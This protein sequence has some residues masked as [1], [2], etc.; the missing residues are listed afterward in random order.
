[1]HTHRVAGF[2]DTLKAARC[3]PTGGAIQADA[4]DAVI[5][6][7]LTQCPVVVTSAHTP[8]NNSNTHIRFL[9]TR[10]ILYTLIQHTP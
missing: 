6:A 7:G 3:V 8:G 10:T 4:L 5:D 1:M 9:F 2:T